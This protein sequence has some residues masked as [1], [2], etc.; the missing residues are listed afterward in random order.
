MTT[1]QMRLNRKL[2]LEDPQRISDGSGGYSE[3]WTPLGEI[4]AQMAPL[5]GRTSG[6]EG[7]SLS[8]QRYRIT[9]RASPV[10]SL[11]RPR[12]GQRFR[13]E[14]RLFRIETVREAD[15]SGRYLACQCL[16]EVAP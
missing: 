11:S 9:L 10:V 1:A 4:W 3:A 7:A 2:V 13:E 15:A 8:L 6:Q 16:E 5:S 14:T 12:P